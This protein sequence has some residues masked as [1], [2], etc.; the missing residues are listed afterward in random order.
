M[1]RKRKKKNKG[2]RPG[3]EGKVPQEAVS[4]VPE[5]A[6]STLEEEAITSRG[7]KTIGAGIA[8]L[9]I[10]FFILTLTDPQGK[11]WASS[12]SPLLI[13]G[14]YAVV[15]LGIFLPEPEKPNQALE[16]SSDTSSSDVDRVEE[17][18][19]PGPSSTRKA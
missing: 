19:G 1:A 10:G 4:A 9:V 14:G 18:G 2:R 13:L 8:L 6:A 7:K 16:E 5:P 15:A 12:I 3:I 17:G 11:N